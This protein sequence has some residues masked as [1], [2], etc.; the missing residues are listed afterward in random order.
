[1]G[2]QQPASEPSITR[3]SGVV[4][5]PVV[6]LFPAVRWPFVEI[7]AMS[8]LLLSYIWIWGSASEGGFMLCVVLYFGIGIAAHWRAKER[9]RDLGIRIDNF[10]RAARDAFLTTLA[11]GLVLG[12]AG[13]LLGGF[14]FPPLA[15]WPIVLRDGIIWGLMQ[16]Y[17]L[18]TIYYRR[19][20]TLLPG[21]RDEPLWA[22]SAVFAILHLPNPFLTFATLA[23]GA[24]SCWLY[25]RTPNVFVLGIMHGVVSF[26]IIHCLPVGITMGMR[27]GPG[28]LR[29]VW[30]S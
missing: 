16:Q 13:A 19:F 7:A 14:H 10:G 1:M 22:A 9:P 21:H 4:R 2:M 11:I 30:G 15:D 3:S 5:A 18:L 26:L 25:R 28:F 23:A 27:V 17:G 6:A 20:V 24:V 29:F 12:G 8:A